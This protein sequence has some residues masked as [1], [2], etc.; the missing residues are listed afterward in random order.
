MVFSQHLGFSQPF[1]IRTCQFPPQI[2]SPRL[3]TLTLRNDVYLFIDPSNFKGKLQGKVVAITGAGR[4]IGK[5]AALAFAD[6]GAS[7]ACIARTAK[8][9]DAVVEKIHS[10]FS[11]TGVEAIAVQGDVSNTEDHVKIVSEI[12]SKLEEI[13]ILLNWAGVTRFGAFADE[14][15]MATGG[16]LLRLICSVVLV[17]FTLSPSQCSEDG[18]EPSQCH[19]CFWKS[20]YSLQHGLCLI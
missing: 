12:T 17:W 3:Q 2:D 7:V 14:Q 16:V 13:D 6:A 4:G 9:S 5:A 19:K 11:S 20:R 1:E 10:S 8:D 18:L 15:N